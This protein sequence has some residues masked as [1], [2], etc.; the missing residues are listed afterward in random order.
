M[1]DNVKLIRDCFEAFGRGDPGFIVARV[2]DDVDWRHPGGVDVPYGGSYKGRD[3]VGQ[4]FSKIGQS[5]EVTSWQPRHVLAAGDEVVATGAWAGKARSTGKSFASD[6]GM[7][8]GMRDGR[9]ASFR[10]VED[11][12]QLAAAFRP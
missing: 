7:V 6:W 1:A 2:C 11:T 4:F 12:A 10:V 3:G 9:I 5:V 8:F